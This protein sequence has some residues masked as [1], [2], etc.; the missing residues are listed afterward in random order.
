MNISQ[1]SLFPDL[2]GFAQSLRT[3][4]ADPDTIKQKVP[5]LR[6]WEI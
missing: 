2:G 1:A 4:L 5:A 6:W 3:R